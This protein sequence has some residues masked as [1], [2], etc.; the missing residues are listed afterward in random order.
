MRRSSQRASPLTNLAFAFAVWRPT[1]VMSL[2]Y[3]GRRYVDALMRGKRGGDALRSEDIADA[4]RA[5]SFACPYGTYG[6]PFGLCISR[7]VA[8][9]SIC[10]SIIGAPFDKYSAMCQATECCAY[11]CPVCPPIHHMDITYECRWTA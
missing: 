11:A 4:V 1:W 7:M 6:R 8:V 5:Y 9:R 2:S 3:G 10:V